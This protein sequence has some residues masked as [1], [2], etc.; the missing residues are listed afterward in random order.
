MVE[1]AIPEAMAE[2]NRQIFKG[3]DYD[4]QA[5]VHTDEWCLVV[6]VVSEHKW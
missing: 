2:W 4:T 6:F 1:K 5:S 3:G